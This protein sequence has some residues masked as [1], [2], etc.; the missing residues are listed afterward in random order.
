MSICGPRGKAPSYPLSAEPKPHLQQSLVIRERLGRGY[1]EAVER[2]CH[3]PLCYR[4]A[5]GNR[6]PLDSQARKGVDMG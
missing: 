3:G 6:C 4:S 2:Q 5:C 1:G